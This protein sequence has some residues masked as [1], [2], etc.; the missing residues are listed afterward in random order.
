MIYYAVRRYRSC[1]PPCPPYTTRIRNMYEK[2]DGHNKRDTIFLYHY[3]Y[4]FM[5]ETFSGTETWNLRSE[6]SYLTFSDIIAPICIILNVD[7][8]LKE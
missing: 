2:R 1:R 3:Y 4:L 8:D 7:Q 6:K 5:V